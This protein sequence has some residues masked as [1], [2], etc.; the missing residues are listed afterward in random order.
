MEAAAVAGINS[1]EVN[2]Y[3]RQ[4]QVPRNWG[5]TIMS[6]GL[7]GFLMG[8]D[9]EGVTDVTEPRLSADAPYISLHTTRGDNDV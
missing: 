6:D 5:T 8:T 7:I 3:L 9:I 4:C 1:K 2:R